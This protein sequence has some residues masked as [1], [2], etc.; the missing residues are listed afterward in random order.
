MKA[1]IVSKTHMQN[2]ACVGA[3]DLTNN[4]SIRL[5]TSDGSNQ[6]V[7]TD[8]EV[9]EI[10]DIDYTARRSLRNPHIEDVL[11][12]KKVYLSDQD[13][14]SEFF[15]TNNDIVIWRGGPDSLFD[16]MLQFTDR[17]SGYIAHNSGIPANSV[18]FWIPDKDLT[19][20]DF[21]EKVRYQYALSSFMGITFSKR[22]I[23]YVGFA[24]PVEVI[25]KDTLVR[26]SLARWWKQDENT[27]ER[28]YLQISGWYL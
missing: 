10:W 4:Q 11:V 1:L 3:L 18:G 12:S 15:N 17:G 5:L 13:N 14:L 28:C 9:G 6:P 24:P 19:R 2:A 7:D 20:D 27:E 16:G 8:F 21:K 22:T 25:E 26:V 23:P